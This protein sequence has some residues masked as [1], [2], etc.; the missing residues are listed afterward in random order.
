M[1]L[2]PDSV[3]RT[4][5]SKRAPLSVG[6][7][8]LS[9]YFASAKDSILREEVFALKKQALVKRHATCASSRAIR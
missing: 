1:R 6:Q 5:L 8:E 9:G 7:P 3:E 4:D 2:V